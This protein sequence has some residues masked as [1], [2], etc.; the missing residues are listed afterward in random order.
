MPEVGAIETARPL[1]WAVSRGDSHRLTLFKA[2]C[3]TDRLRAGLLFHQQQLAPSE[4]FVRLAQTD[5]DLKRKKD[6]AVQILVEAIEIAGGVTQQ[7]GCGALLARG[8]TLFQEIAQIEW[9][10]LRQTQGLH[11]LSSCIG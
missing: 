3:V 5:H 8:M 7:Q 1:H 10:I 9:I 6:L 4:L 11:P 2:D